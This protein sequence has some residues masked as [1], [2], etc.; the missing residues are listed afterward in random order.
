MISPL[1]SVLQTGLYYKLVCNNIRPDEGD[2]KGLRVK[3]LR[4]KELRVKG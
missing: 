1:V 2:V 4:V 3:G